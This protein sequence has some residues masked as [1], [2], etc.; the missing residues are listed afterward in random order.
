MSSWVL[1]QALPAPQARFASLVSQLARQP[2]QLSY[3]WAELNDWLEGLSANEFTVAVAGG[4]DLPP[5]PYLAN[6]LAAMIELAAHRKGVRPPAWTLDVT[7]LD[8]PVFASSLQGLR[9][10]LLISSPPPFRRRNI[11]IDTSVGGRV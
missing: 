1:Q 3:L 11:F 5:S 9:L 2:D 6:Y 8:Q 7:P 4:P 10:H